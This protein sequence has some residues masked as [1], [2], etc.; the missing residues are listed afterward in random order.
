MPNLSSLS[1]QQRSALRAAAH[2]LRPVVLIG[3]RGLTDAVLKEIDRALIVHGLIK[4]RAGGEDRTSREALLADICAALSC[5]PVHH[6]GKILI[7]YRPTE[8]DAAEP[9]NAAP[10]RR[11]TSE[12]HT[13]K[14]LA[15]EGKMLNKS[16]ARAA[17]R[18]KPAAVPANSELLNKKGRPARPATTIGK[19]ANAPRP[20]VSRR[21]GSALSLRAGARHGALTRTVGSRKTSKTPRG[22]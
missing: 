15:A 8:V 11:K 22:R 4:V 5:H 20:D 3:D 2:A 21:G 6:L 19:S 7:L 18:R 16:A 14:K 1:S 10:A 17:M 13:P 9:A 12:P